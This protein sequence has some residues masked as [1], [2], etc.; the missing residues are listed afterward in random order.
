MKVM[1]Q[2]LASEMKLRVINI[3]FLGWC[4]FLF[5]GAG[6]L[7]KVKVQFQSLCVGFGRGK[8]REV[9]AGDGEENAFN[10]ETEVAF[11]LTESSDL[12]MLENKVISLGEAVA[13]R[14]QTTGGASVSYHTM[15]PK[16]GEDGFT[17]KQDKKI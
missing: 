5:S 2:F 15:A 6:D 8:W 10:P 4:F 3:F 13:T 7:C 9:K 1:Q 12:V 14:N 11:H 17:L 16:P